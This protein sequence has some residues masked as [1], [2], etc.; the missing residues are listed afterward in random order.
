MGLPFLQ[1][2]SLPGAGRED[3]LADEQQTPALRGERRPEPHRA[4]P[5]QVE[6]AQPVR[7]VSRLDRWSAPITRLVHLTPPVIRCPRLYGRARH[8]SIASVKTPG[9]SLGPR[10]RA[11][12]RADRG[13][14]RDSPGAIVVSTAAEAATN[15]TR[16]PASVC[17]ADRAPA[18][19][20]LA[21]AVKDRRDGGFRGVDDAEEA[22]E[23]VDEPGGR[24]VLGAGR[25]RHPAAQRIV[26]L[27]VAGPRRAAK[28]RRPGYS[29]PR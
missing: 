14:D 23:T 12:A 8:G 6:L 22:D 26:R 1:R 11:L 27:D 25:V 5:A 16:A 21:K 3:G 15:S 10:A 20:H 29:L 13:C 24:H 4:V 17:P 19:Q 18:G 2:Y 28:P 9:R 7:A